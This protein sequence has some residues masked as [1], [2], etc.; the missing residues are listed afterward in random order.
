MRLGHILCG[1]FGWICGSF[2]IHI[3]FGIDHP[4]SLKEVIDIWELD[5]KDR[6]EAIL[7]V[8]CKVDTRVNRD[9]AGAY[10]EEKF[11]SFEKGMEMARHIGASI[12]LECSA[13]TGENIEEVF[14]HAVRLS[15]RAK[16]VV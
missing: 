2:R 6:E 10:H 14:H 9:N 7:L 16:A 8:G 5:K 11:V 15:L 1:L 13:K 12:Y 3:L 4:P